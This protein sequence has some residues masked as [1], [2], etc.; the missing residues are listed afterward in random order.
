MFPTLRTT[1]LECIDSKSQGVSILAISAYIEKDN[2]F[3][4][5]KHSNSFL[6]LIIFLYVRFYLMKAILKIANA[7]KKR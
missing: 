7:R 1:A 2:T 6:R 4:L 3:V 5:Q